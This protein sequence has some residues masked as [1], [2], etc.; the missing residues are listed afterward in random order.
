MLPLLV[1]V[2][3]SPADGF[4]PAGQGG[5]GEGPWARTS[6]APCSETRAFGRVVD[7]RTGAAIEGARLFVD[8]SSGPR[9]EGVRG[10]YTLDPGYTFGRPCAVTNSSGEFE[11]GFELAAQWRPRLRASAEGWSSDEIV[12][13]GAGTADLGP[14]ALRLEPALR[15][16]ATIVWPD[17]APAS[18]ASIVFGTEM[19]LLSMD[20]RGGRCTAWE[21][22]GD[23]GWA[24]L[25][26]P[27]ASDVEGIATVA[28]TSIGDRRARAVAERALPEELLAGLDAVARTQ[29][30]DRALRWA[31]ECDLADFDGKR[32]VL[33][34]LSALSGRVSTRDGAPIGGARIHAQ[35]VFDG[36]EVVLGDIE[37]STRADGE[38][39]YL[40]DLLAPGRWTLD[41][42]PQDGTVAARRFE[43]EIRTWHAF[44]LA[45][46]PF[47]SITGV[48]YDVEGRPMPGAFVSVEY[49]RADEPID[50]EAPVVLSSCGW[51][52]P[53][54]WRRHAI[55]RTA[56][57]DADGVF[58]FEALPPGRV[59]LAPTASDAVSPVCVLELQGA[60]D[61]LRCDLRF[62]PAAAIEGV[63]LDFSGAPIPGARVQALRAEEPLRYYVRTTDE[64]GRFRFDGLPAGHWTVS[65]SARSASATLDLDTLSTMSVVLR[66]P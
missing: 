49:L 15:P 4:A 48:L 30:R 43:V 11:F 37:T 12:L 57:T 38:G 41:V 29:F 60:C 5:E 22:E 54:S 55:G 20:G 19:R 28:C 58:T 9:F 6:D 1:A 7:A 62:V 33:A 40:L 46:A 47:A 51:G 36:G 45:L 31:A 24:P 50:P 53:W 2:L 52:R 34:P 63:A 3:L 17:G 21:S 44:D 13:G 14:L 8:S 32:L 65:T 18:G 66:E 59:S 27:V 42:F 26:R 39:R 23:F 10:A 61:V 56:R 16:R 64:R 35:R 25:P